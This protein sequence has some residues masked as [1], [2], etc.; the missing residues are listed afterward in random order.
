MR[1]F[2]LATCVIILINIALLCWLNRW[3]RSR[4]GSGFAI[5]HLVFIVWFSQR[6][7]SG[8]IVTKDMELA[9]GWF[10]FMF[11]DYFAALFM[12]LLSPLLGSIFK[13]PMASNFYSHYYCFGILGTLQFY[14]IGV[15]MAWVL[16]KFIKLFQK[17][18]VLIN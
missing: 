12:I 16:K 5:L 7:L 4:V 13:G 2:Y 15:F 11:V 18:K 9:F 14:F 17:Q 8:I 3:K 6:M 1:M 10:A